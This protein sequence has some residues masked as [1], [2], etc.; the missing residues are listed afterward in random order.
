MAAVKIEHADLPQHSLC[1]LQQFREFWT[2][3]YLCDVVLKSNDGAE[4]RAHAAV[5]SAT[6]KFFKSLLGGSFLEADRV[7]RGQ[8]VEIAASKTAVSALLDY[9]YG[10]QPE[11]NLEAGVELLR[12]AEAYDLP[13]LASAIEAGFHA[14]LDSNSALQILQEAHGLHALKR[15]CEEKVAQ[16]FEA[17]SQHP[18]FGKLDSG[19]LA[20]ILKR[21][22]L[23]VSREEEVLKGLFSWLRVS[24]DRNASLAMLLQ[25]VDFHSI[26]V[27]NLLRLGRLS[28]SG[29]TG[30]YLHRE[31]NEALCQRRIQS[32]QDFQP[33]R[34]CLKT[35]SQD[36]GAY[37]GALGHKVLDVKWKHLRW[38]EGSIYAMDSKGGI[39][40]WK[41]GDPATHVRQLVGEGATVIGI[42][43]LGR[44]SR[45][46]IGPTGE[47][48]VAD[49]ENKILV[50]FQNGSGRLVDDLDPNARIYCSPNGV[51]YVVTDKALQKLE[52]SRLQTVVTFES[53][54]ED[55]QFS[56]FAM[57]VTKEEV[58]YVLD[59]RYHRILRFN[60]TESFKPVVVGQVP[61]EHQPDLW[62]IFVTEGGTLYI[63]DAG[64]DKVLV[65]RPG[66]ADCTEVFESGGL[67][68]VAVLIHDRS[69]YVSMCDDYGTEGGLME[70]VFP[71]EL[72]L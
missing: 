65:I 35:W 55:L 20:R 19:Q 50:T 16:D 72:H 24:K 7:Q 21:E 30:D 29:P 12:L 32:S 46:A 3:D 5:L 14:S 52:G 71:P 47:I 22:D 15:A 8:P 39:Q 41:P 4:H 49:N 62:D 44:N 68:P 70:C 40:C 36:W 11:V 17:C 48:F 25:L 58:I 23:A 38:H 6:S 28:L 69:L 67:S 1:I 18:D 34:H 26:A 37:P 42:K 51:L 63:A 10:G 45:F 66:E 2:R 43:A 64:Q 54:P 53:L 61:I 31:V 56:A 59:I 33:K 13:K 57:F 60:P 9:V 27:E